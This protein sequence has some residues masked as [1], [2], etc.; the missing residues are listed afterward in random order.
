MY[1]NCYLPI[2]LFASYPTGPFTISEPQNQELEFFVVKKRRVQRILKLQR[3]E[4]VGRVNSQLTSSRPFNDCG[5]NYVQSLLVCCSVCLCINS[6]SC[7]HLALRLEFRSAPSFLSFFLQ[8]F[9]A[10]GVSAKHWSSFRSNLSECVSSS[11]SSRESIK[12]FFEMGNFQCLDSSLETM[13]TLIQQAQKRS[14][15]SF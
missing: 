12:P 11:D 2:C 8:T 15:S 7:C 5:R 1:T 13:D 3:C 4:R 9:A 14:S 6:Y 10:Y